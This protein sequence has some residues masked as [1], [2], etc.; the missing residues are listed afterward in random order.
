M[1]D[2]LIV[3][4]GGHAGS[5]ADAIEQAG[6][7]HIV[8]Y[9]D[10]ARSDSAGYQWL[11]T[12]DMLE[13]YYKAGIV[14]VAIGIGYL[15]HGKTRDRLYATV[16]KIGYQLPAIVDKSAVIAKD[17]CIG[18]G[19]FIGKGAVINTGARIGKMCIINSGAVVEH[20]N[21]IGDF[22]HVAVGAILCGGVQI[23]EHAF[24]GAGATVIQGIRIGK[25]CF[26]SA[27]NIVIKDLLTNKTT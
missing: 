1:K 7:Y 9:T 14:N 22:S 27:G 8:G 5:I 3:G 21:C 19:T 18:E 20:G 23:G 10:I 12:D 6:K 17:V 13:V 4:Y 2:I 25:G 11:G 16:K 24:I 15:G 26:V